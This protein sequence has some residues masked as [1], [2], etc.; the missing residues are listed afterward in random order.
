M[1]KTALFNTFRGMNRVSDR[2]NTDPTFLYDLLN[3]YV[4]K[5]VKSGLGIITQ[6]AGCTKFNTTILATGDYGS[7]KKIRTIF[8][9]KW[10]GGST[11]VIIRAGTAWGKF[12]GGTEFD[13]IDTARTDDALGQCV[14]FKNELIMVDGAKARKMTSGYSVSDLSSDA[15]MP[16]KSDAVW[17]HRD[18]LWLNDTD[19]P[20]IAYFSKTNNANGATAWTGTTDAGTIDLSTVLPVGDRIRGFRTYGGR[21]SGIIAIICDKYTAIYSAGANT[22]DFTFI[23]YFPTTCLSMNAAAYVGQD[24]VYPSRNVLTSIISSAKNQELDTQSLSKYVEPLYRSLV[25]NVTTSQHISGVF[26]HTLNLYYITFPKT[27]DS[28]TLVFSADIGNVVGR[29]TYPFDIYSW[30]ERQSGVILAGTD[31]YV[32]TM[33]TGYDDGGTAISFKASMPALYF[34]TPT[35]YKRPKDIEA[36]LYAEN[37]EPTVNL[38]YWH[39][40][41]GLQTTDTIRKVISFQSGA[42]LYYW[43]TSSW[44][45]SYW[46][47]VSANY[48]YRTRDLIGRGRFTVVEISHNTLGARLTIIFFKVGYVLEGM[49]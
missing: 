34:G 13:A 21:D 24:L 18:K 39:G 10:D 17:V 28:Q 26:D 15:N 30:A 43:D 12:D 37:Q 25:T 35:N 33:N 9:A 41:L 20:M 27:N 22:Y 6:R 31:G 36:M 44:D 3:G 45:V 46:S 16:D 32:Y 7:T 8:E 11:D 38:D 42:T 40:G 47:D 49:N 14:M 4:K 19:T 1:L 29:Y 48:L 2:L 5:D 23:Q